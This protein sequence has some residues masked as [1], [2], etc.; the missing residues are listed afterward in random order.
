MSIPYAKRLRVDRGEGL[1][2][3]AQAAGIAFNT[4]KKVEAGHEVDA[5]SLKK[6]GE[7]YGVDASSLL[8]GG[9]PESKAVA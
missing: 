1:V 9:E 6:L 3:V 4:L 5:G 8:P 2:H 7:Y